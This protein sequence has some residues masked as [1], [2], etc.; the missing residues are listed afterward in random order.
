[1]G[2]ETPKIMLFNIK[3]RLGNNIS[4]FSTLLYIH[5][6]KCAKTICKQ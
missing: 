6:R 2:N 3:I 5:V 1:M 4:E